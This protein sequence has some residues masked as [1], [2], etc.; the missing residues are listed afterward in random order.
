MALI[1]DHVSFAYEGSP[2]EVVCDLTA[3]F[4]VG[5]SGVVGANGI[6]KSTVL[7]LASGL[8]IPIRGV[9]RDNG[10][11]IYCPQRTDAAPA[12]L[13]EFT[14]DYSVEAI[15]LRRGLGIGDDWA[16]RWPSLSHGE[17]KRA[18]LAAALWQD[19]DVLAID[20]PTN[21]LDGE[22]RRLIGEALR[23]FGGVGILVSH[24]RAL[25]DDLCL[26]CLFLEEG[27]ATMRPGGYSIGSHLR[28]A[29]QEA[30][31]TAREQAAAELKRLRRVQVARR[32]Q[33]DRAKAKRS[34]KGLAR[35]DSDGRARRQAAIVSGK[36]GQ[37]GRLLSQLEGRLQHARE[38]LAS[39]PAEKAEREGIWLSSAR[40]ARKTVVS[41]AAGSITVGTIRR[42]SYPQLALG[43]GD[44]VALTGPNGAGKTTLLVRLLGELTLPSQRIVYVPQEISAE[45]SCAL[46]DEIKSSDETTLGQLLTV[47]SR[48]GSRPERVLDSKLPSPGETRK[49]LLAMGVLREPHIVIM[50]EP[51]NHLDLPAIESLEAALSDTPCAL[52]LVSH[53]R[54]FLS[55]LCTIEWRFES[56][57]EETH[58]RVMAMEAAPPD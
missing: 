40:S 29:K 28:I 41:L 10:L 6:G 4:P 42:L 25:L 57:G 17:R 19:P 5:W 49:L 21:H 7:Q 44:R 11:A 46:L 37:A 31:H 34:A 33:A 51:T 26:Q 8:L 18:Q 23:L 45:Q 47:V 24:D 12:R 54:T 50:D 39:M 15:A 13:D 9:V 22:A 27:T 3:H 43:P 16:A 2:G 14:A 56:R 38:R 1:F 52:L 35:H 30:G 55:R 58:L 32:S 53:D 36:D 20:E 48:L